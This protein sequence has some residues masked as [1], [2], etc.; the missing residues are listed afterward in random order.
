MRRAAALG[1]ALVLLA[2]A[3]PAPA[4]GDPTAQAKV[5]FN[6]GAQ[7]YERTQFTAAIQAFE[8]A[9]KLAPRPGVLFSIAQA[10]RRRYTVDKRPGD[11]QIAIARYRAYLDT[12]PE[13]GRR[14]DAV[15]ALA[16]LEPIA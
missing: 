13:G 7:A 2:A 15:Q 5:L 6:A 12:V 4:Q 10:Y 8:E 11:L 16:E 14:K 9:Y 1:A 3:A